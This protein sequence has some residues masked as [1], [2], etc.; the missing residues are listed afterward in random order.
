MKSNTK[1]PLVIFLLLLLSFQGLLSSSRR[2]VRAKHGMVVS[3]EEVASKVGVQILRKGGTAVD[4]AVAVGFA[5]AVTFPGAGNI[6]GG[7][8]MVIRMADGRTVTIDY[9]EKA[10]GAAH[11]DMFL[12]ENGKYVPERSQEGYLSTGVPGSVAGLLHAL[13]KYGTMSRRVVM[14]PA[15]DL[16]RKG[17]RIK[18]EFA[19]ELR[20]EIDDIR[21]YPS[22]AKI[23]TKRGEPFEE[24]HLLIQR[25]LARTL[26]RI[27]KSG[28]N[29]FYRGKTAD[30]IV[31]EMK[32]GGG[33]ITH[34][35][36]GS[37]QAVERTPVQGSY[38]GLEIVSMGPPSSGGMMLVQMLNLL[39]PFNLAGS[40]FGSSRAISYLAEAMKL[41]YADRAQFMGDADFF[42]VPV[43][44]L[45][46]KEY[47]NERRLLLDT[48]RATPSEEILHGAIELGEK[49]E[50]THYSVV[51]RWGNAVAV[52]TTL[53]GWYGNKIVVAGAGFFLNNEM[54]DFSAK[55]GAPNVYG[56]VGGVANS[57]EPNKRMLSSMTPTIVL[58]DG[59]PVMVLGSPGGSTII[60]TVLQVFL[61]VVEH[62]MNIA[63]AINAP[64]F[65]HQWLPDTLVYEKRGFPLDV[66]VNLEQR[67]YRLRERNGTQGRVEGIIIDRAKGIL[68]GATDPRGYGA[69]IGY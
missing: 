8:F 63:E 28:R 23:F 68:Y 53:N 48:T 29:G 15:I 2:P 27:Q 65:H 17:F 43:G 26:Q 1:I 33:L 13:E 49:T 59:Q 12:D 38:K 41:A 42:P 7:G 30:L 6:G 20:G 16:A 64:R 52:T 62:R 37:Y 66:V 5:L 36:L 46:S 11:R 61:N 34:E 14:Q 51:D 31:A 50:T 21:K 10:P 32:R 3:A 40:G 25:D 47:A 24:G 4:A 57:V 56:L 58:E 69:A 19:E 9:R 45:I 22:T 35:D 55:V 60:T 44:R 67:G 18:F 39:E 54:D